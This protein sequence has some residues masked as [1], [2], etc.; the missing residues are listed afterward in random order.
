M[1]LTL[2]TEYALRVLLYLGAHPDAPVST[3]RIAE[4]FCISR[5]HLVRVVQGLAQHGHVEVR[6][7]RTGGVRLAREPHE[8]RVGTV[9]RQM[10]PRMELVECSDP[11]RN[12]CPLLPACGLT[13]VLAEARQAF[14]AAL[15]AHT[16]ADLLAYGGPARLSALLRR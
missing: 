15:D 1:H 16:L 4:A 7:G 12:P 9:V 6:P 14:L 11:A 13:G 10:E 2:H 5:H 8:V 3:E